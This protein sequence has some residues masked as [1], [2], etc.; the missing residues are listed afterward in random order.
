MQ[1]LQIS[2][3][4]DMLDAPCELL[5]V[6]FLTTPG[7]SNEIRTQHLNSNGTLSVLQGGR[8]LQQIIDHIKSKGGCKLTGTLYKH[9]LM[10]HFFILYPGGPLFAQIHHDVPEFRTTLSH[11]FNSFR[12]GDVRYHTYFEE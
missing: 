8:S 7:R 6:R 11:K 10:D 3:D 2:F 9:H 4:I 12:M 1:D 5:D